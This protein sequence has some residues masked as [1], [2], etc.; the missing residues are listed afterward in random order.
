M[1]DTAI[2]SVVE[3][4]SQLAIKSLISSR[5][6]IVDLKMA[7]ESSSQLAVKN[8]DLELSRRT[9]TCRQEHRS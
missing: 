1:I 9:S 3:A 8:A 5:R 4:P 6:Q 2:D 7:I